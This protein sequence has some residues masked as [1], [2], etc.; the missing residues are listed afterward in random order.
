MVFSVSA[1]NDFS[2]L[3]YNLNQ[4][5]WLPAFVSEW[6]DFS[7]FQHTVENLIQFSM[8]VIHVDVVNEFL[9]WHQRGNQFIVNHMLDQ[10]HRTF[11]HCNWLAVRFVCYR[12]LIIKIFVKLIFILKFQT[13]IFPSYCLTPFLLQLIIIKNHRYYFFMIPFLF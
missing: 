6:F 13:F 3:V 7:K 12:K 11:A 2:G 9:R 5:P 10:K 4:A 8:A 1:K